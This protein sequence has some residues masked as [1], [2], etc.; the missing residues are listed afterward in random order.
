MK[1]MPHDTL[2][3]VVHLQETSLRDYLAKRETELREGIAPAP[4]GLGSLA[5]MVPL[6]CQPQSVY[7]ESAALTPLL[8]EGVA[9][10]LATQLASGCISLVNCNIDS[11]PDTA[12]TSH[13]VALLYQVAERSELASIQAVQAGL[14][15][16][17]ERARPCLL[18][19][20]IHTPNHRWVMS[21]ALAKCYEI[22]GDEAYKR[23]AFQFLDEGFDLTDD[24]EWTER[25]NAIYNGAC[26]IHLYDVGIAFGYE[27]ALDAVRKNLTMMQYMLHPGDTV[28]TEYSGRQ[29]L[30][31]TLP[32]NDWYYVS[33]HL[34]ASLD[35]NPLF[36][37]MAQITEQTSPKGSSVL[38]HWMLYPDAM[39]LPAEVEPLPDRYTAMLG[40]HHEAVVPKTVPYLGALA[41][42]PHGATVVRHRSGK[43]SVTLMAAQHHAMYLQ[44]GK[45]RMFGFKLAAGW[46]GVA[47]VAF[48]TI[49]RLSEQ[50]F[51]M[52]IALEGCYF[53]PLPK[54]A[55][56]A[57]NGRYVD[58]P[59]REREKTHVQHLPLRVTFTLLEDGV[60]VRLESQAI[61]NIYLQ[62]IC[63]FDPEGELTG[64][65]LDE[66]CAYHSQL[67][68]G[69]ATY[70]YEGDT[71]RISSG[72][73]EHHDPTMR[74]DVLNRDLQTMT[75]N[76][77]TPTDVT[78]RF[79]VSE[80]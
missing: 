50:S 53:N 35:R 64:D 30:G 13:L 26:A 20:G 17:L 24:G 79:R 3:S 67:K 36:V 54:D 45:A 80:Q 34:M 23:R 75:M 27:P 51:A 33:Y 72:A 58:F 11:P 22:F 12:F 38:I 55:V 40:E 65:G 29:D 6:F 19:G 48:P 15:T 16:F 77:V 31:Q 63:V 49:R 56:A 8:D 52:D 21:G 18:T 28:A 78:I 44:Y 70:S 62:T 39:P 41:K 5:L 71:I 9:G 14:R 43:L 46:F 7:Y 32:M 47:G 37:S 74:N 57:Y 1:T 59:N 42:H 73:H 10:L 61:P 60:D 4:L 66:R 69:D 76:Y 68:S 25:S 2:Q